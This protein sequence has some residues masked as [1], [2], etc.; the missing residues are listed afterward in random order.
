MTRH[1]KGSLSIRD[2][3]HLGSSVRL[4][5]SSVV[6]S[7]FSSAWRTRMA[8]LYFGC[9]EGMQGLPGLKQYEIR[10]VHHVVDR[11]QTHGLQTSFEPIRA[12]ADL[13]LDRIELVVRAVF[14]LQGQLVHQ[15][16]AL[17]LS[18]SPI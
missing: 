6:I 4:T 3:H 14:S 7:S 5:S 13:D 15:S 2:H 8:P 9:V 12:G 16:T 17:G 11:P 1:D 18:T 10:Y